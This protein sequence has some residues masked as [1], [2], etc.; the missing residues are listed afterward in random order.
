MSPRPPAGGIRALLSHI[1]ACDRIAA[2]HE[3]SSLSGGASMNLSVIIAVTLP[4]LL[5]VLGRWLFAQFLRQNGRILLRLEAI[6][7]H[8]DQNGRRPCMRQPIQQRP[9][10]AL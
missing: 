10:P 9:Q 2:R 4:W 5:I 8:L 6:E 7:D 3:A 1:A